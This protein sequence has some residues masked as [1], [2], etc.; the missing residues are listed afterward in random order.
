[1]RAIVLTSVKTIVVTFQASTLSASSRVACP[2][3]ARESWRSKIRFAIFSNA[4]S[5]VMASSFF[6]FGVLDLVVLLIARRES[7]EMIP[8]ARK[9]FENVKNYCLDTP[10]N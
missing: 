4:S 5:I 10:K 2:Q 6:F 3:E 1:M 9:I 8:L 7:L